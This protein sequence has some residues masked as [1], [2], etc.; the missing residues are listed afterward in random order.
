VNPMMTPREGE[1]GTTG[2]VVIVV[3]DDVDVIVVD[4]LVKLIVP[5]VVLDVVSVMLVYV[6]D[7]EVTSVDVTD[8]DVN[9]VKVTDVVIPD[10]VVTVLVGTDVDERDVDEPDVDES[11]LVQTFLTE[12]L[13]EVTVWGNTKAGVGVVIDLNDGTS[14]ALCPWLTSLVRTGE[15]T[16]PW[17]IPMIASPLAT[18]VEMSSEM[19]LAM[20]L[21]GS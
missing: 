15:A 18:A 21:Q 3:E 8:V 17:P 4:V 20:G 6:S 11:M 9:D 1:I 2:P 12:A 7:V 5:V 10:V 14:V 13:V 16:L 19:L